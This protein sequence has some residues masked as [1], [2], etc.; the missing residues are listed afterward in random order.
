MNE[1]LLN[2]SFTKPFG[3]HTFYQEGEGVSAIS[4]T[5]LKVLEILKLFTYCLLGYHSSSS[6]ERFFWIIRFQPKIPIIQIANS[7]IIAY[8]ENITV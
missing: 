2:L 7:H 4:K 3:T 1:E 6:K 8:F 5:L